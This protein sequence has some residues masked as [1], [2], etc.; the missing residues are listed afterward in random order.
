MTIFDDRIK[1]AH[2]RDTRLRIR[3]ARI[4]RMTEV[5]YSNLEIA[6]AMGIS[7]NYVRSVL[8][9]EDQQAMKLLD[10][11]RCRMC[12]RKFDLDKGRNCPDCGTRR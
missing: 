2:E 1:R 8:E 7:E 3:N 4:R 12:G 9:P 6:N 11:I 10:L 5:G